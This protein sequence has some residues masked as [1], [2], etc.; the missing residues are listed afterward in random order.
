M[1]GSGERPNRVSRWRVRARPG[2]T[3]GDLVTGSLIAQADV[4]GP[5]GRV[6]WVRLYQGGGEL[7]MPVEPSERLPSALGVVAS[8]VREVRVGP[9]GQ[10]SVRVLK[11]PE[12][13][14]AERV[15]H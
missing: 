3:A 15:L 12:W 5:S 10:W 2:G 14:R 8:L 4:T 9:P 11:P 7:G 1:P 6:L 13:W